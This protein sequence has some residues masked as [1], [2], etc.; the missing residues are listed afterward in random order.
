[1]DDGRG[2]EARA[3]CVLDRHLDAE[4][5]GDVADQHRA[6]DAADPLE[7]DR[8]PVGDAL[9]VGPQQVVERHDR[10]VEHERAVGGAAHRCALGIGAAR[11]L[12]GVLEVARRPEEAARGAAR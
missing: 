10:L 6:R 5:D 1:M 2:D 4:L 9:A 7:L 12:E 8:D 3:A 11:L